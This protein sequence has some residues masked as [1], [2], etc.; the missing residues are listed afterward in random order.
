VLFYTYDFPDMFPGRLAGM[1]TN[2][3]ELES[4]GAVVHHVSAGG[5]LWSKYYSDTPAYR[6]VVLVCPD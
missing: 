4:G 1:V 6:T 2:V 3:R 5:Y